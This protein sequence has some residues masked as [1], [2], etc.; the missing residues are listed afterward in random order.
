MLQ[1]LAIIEER[2]I[3]TQLS[4]VFRTGSDIVLR[5]DLA[6]LARLGTNSFPRLTLKSLRH[7]ILII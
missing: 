5:P 6:W 3:V 1:R 2:L 4:K 7:V